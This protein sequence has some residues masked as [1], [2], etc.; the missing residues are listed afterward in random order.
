MLDYHIH[1]NFSIDAEDFT[2]EEYCKRGVELGL[3]E[4]CFT[5]H[6]EFDPLRKHL[7]W[8]ARLHGEVV[9]IG[10]RW[11]EE[12]FKEGIQLQKQ[13][14]QQGIT[15]RLGLEVGYDLGLEEAIAKIVSAYP[16][17]LVLGSVHCIDHIAISSEQ[18]SSKYLPGTVIEAVVTKY[19]QILAHGVDSGLFD[20]VAHLDLYRRHGTKYFGEQVNK[21]YQGK[22]EPILEIMAKKGLGLE[23]NTSSLKQ[24]QDDFYP[25]KEII[26]LAWEKGIRIFT[27]GSDAHRLRELGQ[28][29][30]QA[31]AILRKI[32][33]T[34]SIF[35]QRKPLNNLS[36]S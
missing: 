34:P 27:T 35:S 11:L 4:I 36:N 6:F 32:G 23:I 16:F 2:M 7:D 29:L 28:G 33:T 9:H 19:Y 26:E 31:E 5:P 21:A 25:S 15:V 3:K 30:A 24:G 10:D 8:F 12:Y 20:V 14:A 18:E 1:P 13:Y 17:D 22:L